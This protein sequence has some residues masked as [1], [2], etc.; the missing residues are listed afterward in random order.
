MGRITRAICCNR[1]RLGQ[2]SLAAN[3]NVP[4]FS[5][6]RVTATVERAALRD[7]ADASMHQSERQ[8]ALDVLRAYWSA[9]RL[10]LQLEVSQQSL[11]CFDEASGCRRC[12]SAQRSGPGD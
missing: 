8:I 6:F 1:A 9:R 5:G 10:E 12:P 11:V 7:A 3:P 4:L 2:F